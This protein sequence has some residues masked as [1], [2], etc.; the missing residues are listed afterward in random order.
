MEKNKERREEN[1][2]LFLEHNV[3]AIDYLF[4]VFSSS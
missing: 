2:L 4:V 3:L 1:T